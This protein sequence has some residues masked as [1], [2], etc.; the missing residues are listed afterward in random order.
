MLTPVLSSEMRAAVTQAAEKIDSASSQ[1]EEW[2]SLKLLMERAA[3]SKKQ[4]DKLMEELWNAVKSDDRDTF[5]AYELELE[6]EAEDS[7]AIWA[8]IAA[9]ARVSAE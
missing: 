1:K 2:A 8:S 7:A 6:R 9:T 4:V 5:R 3:T